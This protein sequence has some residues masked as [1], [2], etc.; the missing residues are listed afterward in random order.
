LRAFAGF[1][2]ALGPLGNF[3]V[4]SGV[5]AQGLALSVVVGILAGFTPA[6]GAVRRTVVEVLHEV[7]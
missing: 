5:I 1:N 3:F 6:Y 2:P 4:S 7:F